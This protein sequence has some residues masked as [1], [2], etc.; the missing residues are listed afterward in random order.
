[1]LR[2]AASRTRNALWEAVGAAIDAFAT[3]ECRNDFTAAG[4]EPERW[5]SA[6]DGREACRSLNVL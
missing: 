1:L 6:L 4:Y 5:E 2:K 3:H